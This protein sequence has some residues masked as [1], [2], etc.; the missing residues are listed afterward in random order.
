MLLAEDILPVTLN[1]EHL[2]HLQVEHRTLSVTKSIIFCV[3]KLEAKVKQPFSFSEKSVCLL[4]KN[5]GK[6][7]I[8]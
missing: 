8:A 1:C 2:S 5:S 6:R 3:H 4:L 7:S